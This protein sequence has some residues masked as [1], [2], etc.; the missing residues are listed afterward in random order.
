MIKQCIGITFLIIFSSCIGKYR[1]DAQSASVKEKST[2]THKQSGDTIKIDMP[3]SK[4]N[5]KG[6]KMRGAGKHEG[7]I[8]L[9]SGYLITHNQQ[10]I[11]GNFILDM[12]TIGVTDIPKH[13]TIPRKN[14]NDHLKS[15]DFFDVKAFPTSQFQITSVKPLLSD[16]IRITGNLTLK[17]I[18]KSI[19]FKALYKDNSFSTKF[20]IDRFKWNIAYTGNWADK[21]LVDKAI[22]LNIE[23]RTQ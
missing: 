11:N 15:A 22:E 10:L 7:N 12:S 20:T 19:T 1:S 8:E 14:L 16:S 17:D 9:N 21:T 23:L 13:E 2:Q 3:K 18:T 6:T 4:I 5:W